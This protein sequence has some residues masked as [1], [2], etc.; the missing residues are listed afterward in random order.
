MSNTATSQ[1]IGWLVFT[2][3]VVYMLGL[4]WLYSW[5]MVPAANKFG[6]LALPGFM[7]FLWALSVPLGAFIV[8]IGAALIARVERRILWLL[9]LLVGLNTIWNIA[10]TSGQMIPA[11]FGIGGGLI[12]LF[13]VGSIWQW[14]KMRPTLTGAAKTGSE[15]RM[16][17]Y[18]L[19]IEAAWNLCG[20]FGMGNYVLR[21]ELANKFSVPISSTINAASGVLILLVLGWG[22]T[23][24]GQLV[25]RQIQAVAPEESKVPQIAVAD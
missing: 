17:G 11:L 14:A 9:I 25:A 19:F 8:A 4:D 13:F 18:I 1:K 5:R 2:L 3:G 16:I 23:F 22:F 10:Y 15:L 20:I 6:S 24:F 7:G 12:T 21:P